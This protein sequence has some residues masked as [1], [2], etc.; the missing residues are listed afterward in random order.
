VPLGVEANESSE[1]I[2]EL[3]DVVARTLLHLLYGS[4]SRRIILVSEAS[5][6]YEQLVIAVLGQQWPR[7]RR[8][9]SF[10]TGALAIRDLNFDLAVAPPN[11]LRQSAD[12]EKTITQ[13]RR[14]EGRGKQ[15]LP[16]FKP[17][18]HPEN[19]CPVQ[20]LTQMTVIEG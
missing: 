5:R 2:Y 9:F 1:T 19:I 15:F 10:C 8:N 17:A 18:P 11:A 20:G 4:P 3:D 6:H 7:L 13:S 12:D 14:S 16:D